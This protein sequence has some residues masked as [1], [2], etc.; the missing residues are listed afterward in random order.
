MTE[1]EA[2]S[3]GGR[4]LKHNSYH[5]N[6]SSKSFSK[7]IWLFTQQSTFLGKRSFC[8]HNNSPSARCPGPSPW[9]CN[10]V[11]LHGKGEFRLQI[12]LKL[13]ISSP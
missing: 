6:N 8:V 3:T 7:R 9:N 4:P 2:G 1:M 11:M 10:C 5:S 13:L 12:E